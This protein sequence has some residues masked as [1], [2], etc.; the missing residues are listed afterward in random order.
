M[1]LIPSFNENQN[2]QR[3]N[4][5]SL[6]MSSF[7]GK[8]SDITLHLGAQPPAIGTSTMLMAGSPS[9][10]SPLYIGPSSG[11]MATGDFM[12]YINPSEG[13]GGQGV[14]AT[15]TL[16]MKGMDRTPFVSS[17]TLNVLGPETVEEDASGPLFINAGDW[18]P[19]SGN[20][21]FLVDG[22]TPSSG[23]STGSAAMF[24]RNQNMSC[25]PEELVTNGSFLP[26]GVAPASYGDGAFAA[27][28]VRKVVD[29]YTGP[30]VRLRRYGD[31]EEKDFYDGEILGSYTSDDLLTNGDFSGYPGWTASGGFNITGGQA[32]NAGTNP[33]VATLSQ[34]NPWNGSD[35]YVLELEIVACSDFYQTGMRIGQTHYRSFG[36]YFGILT[37]NN[38]YKILIQAD[39]LSSD[40]ANSEIFE[41][42]ANAGESITIEYVSLRGYNASPAEIWAVENENQPMTDTASSALAHTLYD[43]TGNGRDITSPASNQPSILTKGVARSLVTAYGSNAPAMQFNGSSKYLTHALSP[44]LD[45]SYPNLS[46]IVGSHQDNH[47]GFILSMHKSGVSTTY[48]GHTHRDYI[49]NDRAYYGVRNTGSI[50]PAV[51]PITKEQNSHSIGWST[52]STDHNIKANGGDIVTDT[53]SVSAP[54]GINNISFGRLRDYSTPFYHEGFA[55]EAIIYRTDVTD[56]ISD[57]EKNTNAY[58]GVYDMENGSYYGWTLANASLSYGSAK[59][60]TSVAGSELITNGTFDTDSDWDKAD[61]AIAGGEAYSLGGGIGSI[62]S[63]S[64]DLEAG[65]TYDV[66]INIVDLGGDFGDGYLKIFVGST[67]EYEIIGTGALGVQQFQITPTE[68]GAF[69]ISASTASDSWI[70]DDVSVVESSLSSVTLED[71]TLVSG[72]TYNMSILVSNLENSGGSGTLDIKVGGATVHTI[73]GQGFL[74]T[75]TFSFTPSVSGQLQIASDSNLDAWQVSEVSVMEDN[76]CGIT[77]FIEKDFDLG[78]HTSLYLHNQIGSFEAPMSISGRYVCTDQ[79]SLNIKTPTEKGTTLFNRGFSE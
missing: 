11:V 56:Y 73:T 8:D 37:A 9:Q 53:N 78:Q 10:S 33:S 67:E 44:S 70:V 35:Y 45:N 30:I 1:S 18:E 59:S 25:Q 76:S 71:V 75:Q 63:Q 3:T 50:Y 31:S 20:M 48:I 5:C 26:T 79:M 23:H 28:S 46:S 4:T 62:T 15:A 41:F 64:D 51:S 66:S 12:L 21:T 16:S 38:T 69:K 42:Y 55:S 24:I 65:T 39:N 19:S 2:A 77:L 7:S 61:A 34:N 22:M 32:V 52:G 43:Q 49:G 40:A 58:Y 17:A 13:G 14:Q 72:R 74:G 27:Y 6:V 60:N 29:D 54:T 57:I 36:S 47:L 68:I